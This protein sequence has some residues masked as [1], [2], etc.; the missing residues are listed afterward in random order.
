MNFEITACTQSLV[1]EWSQSRP[2]Q[3]SPKSREAH[4]KVVQEFI[5][6][7]ILQRIQNAKLP[8]SPFDFEGTVEFALR[9]WAVH[10][11]GN[12]HFLVTTIINKSSS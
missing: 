1:D 5:G 3:I 7:E 8:S 2:E 9:A 4:P 11:V 6:D 10:C 12:M